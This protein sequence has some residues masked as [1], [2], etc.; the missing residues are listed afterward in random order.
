MNVKP[1]IWRRSGNSNVLVLAQGR[2]LR[3]EGRSHS[4]E[5]NVPNGVRV[6]ERECSGE[7]KVEKRQN[8]DIVY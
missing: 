4:V 1:L 8:G 3:L 5:E 6:G 2:A 7:R